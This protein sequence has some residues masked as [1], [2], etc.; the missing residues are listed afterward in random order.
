MSDARRMA[1]L[2]ARL[3][4]LYDL[5]EV[6]A[7]AVAR[8]E[9][10]LGE[11]G[12]LDD[13]GFTVTLAADGRRLVCELDG[14]RA[15]IE[16]NLTA[17]AAGAGVDAERLAELEEA[18]AWHGPERLASWMEITTGGMDLGW[19]ISGEVELAGFW[20]LAA[21]SDSRDQLRDSLDALGIDTAS[22]IARSMGAAGELAAI[23][24][25]LP[26]DDVV[27]QARNARTVIDALEV[28]PLPL[29]L[30]QMLVSLNPGP[31]E[32]R[33]WLAEGGVARAGIAVAEP[34]SDLVLAL[35]HELGIDDPEQL[36]MLEA[37]LKAERRAAVEVVRG[38]GGVAVEVSYRLLARA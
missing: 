9:D 17:F 23:A 15:A 20:P 24:L 2:G 19:A 13:L 29:K 33:V 18:C 32:L 8:L 6:P 14:P 7:P 37:T 26:G 30:L 31:A 21:S 22:R 16:A 36:A 28:E 34:G 4:L 1:E 5:L 35:R 12:D 11:V 10:W 27:A 25:A 3:A 38:A